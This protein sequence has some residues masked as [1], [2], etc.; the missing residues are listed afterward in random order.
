MLPIVT[1]ARGQAPGLG[2]R[3]RRPGGARAAPGGVRTMRSILS[4]L[5][6]ALFRIFG[7]D[8]AF[9]PPKKV[10]VSLGLE[11]LKSE[12]DVSLGLG[13]HCL[14]NPFFDV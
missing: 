10:T 11:F 12:K 6:E 1:S 9:A 4:S 14:L 3:S 5:R 7:R 2:A 8:R 13:G